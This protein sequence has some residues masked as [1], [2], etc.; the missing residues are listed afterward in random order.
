VEAAVII[1]WLRFGSQPQFHSGWRWGAR[2]LAFAKLLAPE[3][4]RVLSGQCG[5]VCRIKGE[6]K[7]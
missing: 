7:G 3:E 5:I 1:V 4:L 6:G 2:D